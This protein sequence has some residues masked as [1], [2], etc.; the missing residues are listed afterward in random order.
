M[1]VCACICVC[2]YVRVCLYVCVRV[3]VYVC[4][5]SHMHVPWLSSKVVVR[6][7]LRGKHAMSQSTYMI[8]NKE[9]N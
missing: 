6:Y 7:E 1:R 8:L 5:C 3:C 2:V 9:A 4:V